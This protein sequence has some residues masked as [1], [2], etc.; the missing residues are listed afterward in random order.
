MVTELPDYFEKHFNI[1]G[2]EAQD[3]A[4]KEQ[5]IATISSIPYFSEAINALVSINPYDL[6]TCNHCN[7][8]ISYLK[9]RR[10]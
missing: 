9:I 6:F 3:P 8:H 2:I 7:S 1:A 10:T 5:R 4:F